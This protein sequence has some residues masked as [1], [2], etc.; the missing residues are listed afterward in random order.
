ML[1]TL[2]YYAASPFGKTK[3]VLAKR[4]R[5]E[6]KFPINRILILVTDGVVMIRHITCNAN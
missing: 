6:P 2:C 3:G 5:Y 4:F 1:A